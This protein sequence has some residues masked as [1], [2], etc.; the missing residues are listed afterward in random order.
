MQ[1]LSERL[2]NVQTD[3]YNLTL[4]DFEELKLFL[5]RIK[6]LTTRMTQKL[7]EFKKLISEDQWNEL[8][9]ILEKNQFVSLQSNKLDY[10]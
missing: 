7:R 8:I 3:D 6:W 5:T 4:D 10:N 1:R 9:E 2:Q